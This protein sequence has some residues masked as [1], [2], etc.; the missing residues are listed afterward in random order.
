[1]AIAVDNLATAQE[2][3]N[4]QEEAEALAKEQKEK[5]AAKEANMFLPNSLMGAHPNAAGETNPT[6]EKP[7]TEPKPATK[8][9]SNPPPA[10]PIVS[11]IPKTQLTPNKKPNKDAVDVDKMVYR[12]VDLDYIP[13]LDDDLKVILPA[14]FEA[15]IAN[16]VFEDLEEKKEAEK[17]PQ[18]EEKAKQAEQADDESG[19]KPILP[20]SSMFIFGTDNFIREG[21][22]FIVTLKYFDTLIM[23]VICGSSIALATEDPVDENSPRNVVLNYLDYGFTA[24]FTVEMILKII[25]LGVILHPGAYFR[26]IWNFLDAT[27]VICAL[28]AFAFSESES[29][30]KNLNTIKSLRVLRVLRPLKTINRVPKLKAVFDCVV[31]SLKNVFNILIVYMLFNFIFAVIAVQLFKGKFFYCTDLSKLTKSDCQGQFFS[32][33][34]DPAIPTIEQRRWQRWEFHYDNVL[35]AFLALFTVQTGEGWPA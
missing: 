26:D 33:N 34:R 12:K 29:A 16:G 19:P 15:S 9:N 5:S 25:D 11:N 30:G 31:N 17:K 32:Y 7:K 8:T 22:H 24:V 23:A 13:G 28:F 20:Y 14:S 10:A 1:M 27:V 18:I 3:T 2:M 6:D 4:E 35:Y 21:I